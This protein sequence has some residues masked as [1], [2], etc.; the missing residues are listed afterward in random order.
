M[1]QISLENL[2]NEIQKEILRK[3]WQSHDGQWQFAIFSELGPQKGN[4]LNKRTARA[5]YKGAMYRLLKAFSIKKISNIQQFHSIMQ[6]AMELF[7]AH[8]D[9]KF[10]IE[11]LSASSIRGIITKCGTHDSVLRAG[12]ADIYECGC[13]SCRAGLYEAMGLVVEESCEK[14]LA[15]GDEHCEIIINVK[16][17][18]S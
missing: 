7:H 12:V 4:E 17:M 9:F 15:Q 14:R 11:P 13:F 3:N 6:A 10:L 16:N 2:P 8:G 5:V 18:E 1:G